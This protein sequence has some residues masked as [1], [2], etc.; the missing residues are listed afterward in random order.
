MV[1][2]LFN[3]QSQKRV[4]A[5]QFLMKKLLNLSSYFSD[6]SFGL[7]TRNNNSSSSKFC[8]IIQQNSICPFHYFIRSIT[9]MEP[10]YVLRADA[11]IQCSYGSIPVCDSKYITLY[12]CTNIVAKWWIG[13]IIG[14][15]S[16]LNVLTKTLQ[17]KSK[18]DSYI[19]CISNQSDQ[20]WREKWFALSPALPRT[21]SKGIATQ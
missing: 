18:R 12:K 21:V 15:N 14:S 7:R 16:L 10:V 1:L 6:K 3:S 2:N 19:L 17:R 20:G 13:R 4:F 5:I 9:K 11:R 8:Q